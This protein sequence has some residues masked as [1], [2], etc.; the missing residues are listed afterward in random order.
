M[1][2]RCDIPLP[3][4]SFTILS[5]YVFFIKVSCCNSV[6]SLCNSVDSLFL[7]KY[8]LIR[9][10]QMQCLCF[11]RQLNKNT[12]FQRQEDLLAS[13]VSDYEGLLKVEPV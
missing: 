3:D 13:V 7:Y 10:P 5:F 1:L 6:E 12:V 9:A 2:S 11:Q 4:R 8:I